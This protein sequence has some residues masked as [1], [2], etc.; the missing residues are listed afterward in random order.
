MVKDSAESGR[1]QNGVV[2]AEGS[3]MRYRVN[4]EERSS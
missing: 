4:R 3:D 2:G 1:S